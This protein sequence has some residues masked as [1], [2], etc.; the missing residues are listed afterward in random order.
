M[1]EFIHDEQRGPAADL[2]QVQFR[3]SRNGLIRGDVP[4]Q[5]SARVGLVLGRANCQIVVECA[6]PVRVGEGLLSLKP[7]AVAWHHPAD[8]L[9]DASPDEMCAGDQ[10]RS[11]LPPP[12][13]TAAS[14]SV[15]PVASPAARAAMRPNT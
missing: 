12:G 11:D 2:G 3:R 15:M 7:Q 5:A 13:V 8:T 6:A 10:G 1:V 9:D 14:T 4:G